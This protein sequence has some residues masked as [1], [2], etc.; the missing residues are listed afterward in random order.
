MTLSWSTIPFGAED[1]QTLA[2]KVTVSVKVRLPATTNASVTAEPLK[3]G[4]PTGQQQLQASAILFW[5]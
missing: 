1:S 3:L 5:N 2:K 4:P